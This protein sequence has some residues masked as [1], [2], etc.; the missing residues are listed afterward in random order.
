MRN[1]CLNLLKIRKNL[2]GFDGFGGGFWGIIL[3]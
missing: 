1:E 2:Q 3:G